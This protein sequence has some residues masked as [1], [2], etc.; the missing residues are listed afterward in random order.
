M[1]IDTVVNLS[2]M[3]KELNEKSLSKISKQEHSKKINKI[4]NDIEK[5]KRLKKQ[6]ML[7]R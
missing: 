7:H 6:R 5:M 3:I 1:Q 2:K 4:N